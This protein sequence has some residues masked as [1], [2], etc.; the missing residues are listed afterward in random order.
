MK[1]KYELESI[2]LEDFLSFYDALNT[3]D[4]QYRNT[5]ESM[6]PFSFIRIVNSFS[7]LREFQSH[8]KGKPTYY[9]QLSI[10]LTMNSFDP[11]GT[12]ISYD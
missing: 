10:W 4:S 1:S 11:N 6:R 3:P 7:S 9:S 2:T 5:S 12:P 8:L